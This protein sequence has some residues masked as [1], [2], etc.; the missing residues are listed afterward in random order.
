MDSKKPIIYINGPGYSYSHFEPYLTNIND[1][2][3]SIIKTLN[4]V[5]PQGNKVD[6]DL[7]VE[8][9]NPN[10]INAYAKRGF[11]DG[12]YVIRLS[13]GLSYHVW[14]ASRFMLADH[15]FF[16][17]IENCEIKTKEIMEIGRKEYLANFS[18]FYIRLLHITT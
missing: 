3:N 4:I 13:A 12:S 2:F 18:F 17:W 5:T 11:S 9:T 10:E 16:K 14:L 1:H 7:L 6:I 8:A 15:N